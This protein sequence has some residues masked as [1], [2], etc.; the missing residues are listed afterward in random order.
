MRVINW[1]DTGVIG[2]ITANKLFRE[3]QSVLKTRDHKWR[4]RRLSTT[5]MLTGVALA[6]SL[7]F[8]SSAEWQV[9]SSVT[10]Q[11]TLTDN[12]QLDSSD[13][14]DLASQASANISIVG[15]TERV[16]GLLDGTIS[17]DKYINR[18]NLDGFQAN[19][20]AGWD[21]TLAEDIFTVE[22]RASI[23]E[24][25][26]FQDFLPASGNRSIDGDRSR[27][28]AYSVSPHLR[29]QFGP[30]TEA[31]IR[32]N[33]SGTFFD[34]TDAGDS[35]LAPEDENTIRADA[36]LGSIAEKPGFGW[37]LSGFTL[38]SDEDFKRTTYEGR[39]E[40]PLGPRIRPF[41]RGGHDEFDSAFIDEDERSGDFWGVGAIVNVGPRLTI[42]LE[43]GE[44][45]G[46]TTGR[47]DITYEFSET[48]SLR[49]TYDEDVLTRQQQ[50]QRSLQVLGFSPNF[51]LI[52]DI[53]SLPELFDTLQDIQ[54]EVF[55]EER[56]RVGLNG[57]FSQT[58]IQ[59]NAYHTRREFDLSLTQ[60]TTVG[61]SLSAGR[62]ISD[63]FS[64]NGSV[65]YS[66]V[67][68]GQI[69]LDENR[70][71]SLSF[72][73]RYQLADN[74]FVDGRYQFQRSER[75]F[76]DDTTENAII[77]AITRTF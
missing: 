9:E 34:D 59:F 18:E 70:R 45:F 3:G 54:N 16:Q 50:L 8:A 66:E 15:G 58:N 67:T 30:S 76:G 41:V 65:T 61:A 12:A 27:I 32:L 7:N 22:S 36:Y 51:Q 53:G 68:E 57:T 38:E 10:L 71:Y 37:R 69:P 60:E 49:I 48:T 24:R 20:L 46:D 1:I 11:E 31:G 13:R 44:R 72:G 5:T 21:V 43:G 42:D 6:T 55:K 29:N 4:L 77:A 74:I 62:E 19:L 23:T 35:S 17:Y 75:D 33:A 39:I 2:P 56:L 40:T 63:V 14:T 73:G 52:N 26:L 25:N 64:I 28:Y 47:A